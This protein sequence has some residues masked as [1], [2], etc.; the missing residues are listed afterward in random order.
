MSFQ[1]HIISTK[2]DV[3]LHMTVTLVLQ[4]R[5]S[6]LG[7]VSLLVSFHGQRSLANK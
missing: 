7:R 3:D 5:G 1:S 4:K 6:H 2:T